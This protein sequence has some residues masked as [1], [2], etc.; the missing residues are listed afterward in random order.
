MRR[1]RS[2]VLLDEKSSDIRKLL[3]RLFDVVIKFCNIQNRLYDVVLSEAERLA[4]RPSRHR[5]STADDWPEH[6]QR[7]RRR[8]DTRE[9][10]KAEHM[11][12]EHRSHDDQG[13]G[14]CGLT[15]PGPE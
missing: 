7:R 10:R 8:S 13:R 15:G 1:T 6:S 11:V 5:A 9:Y 2:Q 4:R 14:E 12:R 3:V